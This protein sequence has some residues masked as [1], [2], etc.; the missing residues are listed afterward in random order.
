MAATPLSEFQNYL[1]SI[2]NDWKY[3]RWSKYYTSTDTLGK[4][5]PEFFEMDLMV[6]LQQPQQQKKEEFS[7]EKQEKIERLQVLEGI[8][9]YAKDHVLLT[10]RPGSGK[11]TALERLLWEEARKRVDNELGQIP[12]LV[13][14]RTYKTSVFDIIHDF[15]IEHNFYKEK[16]EIE[17]LL[18]NSQLLLLIDG[19]NE[20]PNDNARRDLETFRRKYRRNTAMIFTSRDISLGGNLGIDKANNHQFQSTCW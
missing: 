14:L 2:I 12:V 1:E 18:L 5:Q 10:G 9:K 11:T 7:L 20:L 17:S 6:E 4:K 15:F 8:R 16:T 19:L 3:Q 13:R